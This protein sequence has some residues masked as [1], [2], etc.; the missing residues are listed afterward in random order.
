MTA[1]SNVVTDTDEGNYENETLRLAAELNRVRNCKRTNTMTFWSSTDKHGCRGYKNYAVSDCTK[2]SL[3][4]LA[5][6][7]V[8]DDMENSGE[9]ELLDPP[10]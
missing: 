1:P 2:L 8:W 3:I 10:L 5:F 4:S 9:G 6:H 7:M